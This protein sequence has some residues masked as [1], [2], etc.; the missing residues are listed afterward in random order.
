MK[1]PDVEAEALSV[2]AKWRKLC[3]ETLAAVSK[4]RDAWIFQN[5]VIESPELSHEDKVAYSALIPEPMD[6]RT[7]RKN[8]ASF[9]SPLEF[10]YDMTLVFRNCMTFNKP[11][12]DAFEM[13]KD[14]ES[15]FLAKWQLERRREMALAFW[16]K[17][18]ELARSVDSDILITSR[19][20]TKT[21]PPVYDAEARRVVDTSRGSPS[22]G[23]ASPLMSWRSVISVIFSEIKNNSKFAW[24]EL[25]VHK[26]TAIALEVKRQ[27]YQLVRNPMDLETIS[28][29]LN[30]YPSPAEFRKDLELIVTNSVRFNPPESIVNFAARELQAL[31]THLFDEKFKRELEPY[32]MLSNEW[33]SV[34]R[35]PPQAPPADVVPAPVT[36]EVKPTVLRIKRSMG[37]SEPSPLPSPPIGDVPPPGAVSGTPPR[38]TAT[39]SILSVSRAMAAAQPPPFG[40]SV[41]WRFFANHCLNELNAIRDENGNRLTWIFQ[42]PI[43]KYELPLTIKRLYLLSITDL[44]DLATVQSKL[45]S[46]EY[47]SPDEFEHDVELMIDNCLIF[48]D[49]SQYPHKLGFVLQKHFREYWG[50]LRES[51]VQ[52]WQARASIAD[53][54]MI[55]QPLP[56]T[57]VEQPNWD[58]IKQQVMGEVVRPNQDC[59]SVSAAFPLNDELLY[60]WRVSQRFVMQQLRKR[61]RPTA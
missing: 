46:G 22:S 13:G 33:R 26:Y 53:P 27:Y 35:I 16:Q 29:N 17:S 10:E 6:F 4:N 31:I 5:P 18:L 48:N 61:M 23:S 20:R 36:S 55:A 7:I 9:E 38:P 56:A 12:Q 24:F 14:V 32:R 54:G 34:K 42:K 15:F 47:A 30:G 57:P 60:E 19:K 41:D 51:A 2:D 37:P 40:Q 49:E 59:D 43:F 50:Q 39:P 52:A 25:P 45:A 8:I 58:E 44:M 11:G 1:S 28:K 3:T 21:P